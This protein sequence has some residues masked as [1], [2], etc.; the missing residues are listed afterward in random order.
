LKINIYLIIKPLNNFQIMKKLA[1]SFLAI[2][3]YWA[4][5]CQKAEMLPSSK[6]NR[7]ART[8]AAVTEVVPK[9]GTAN[10]LSYKEIEV[11][12]SKWILE[13]PIDESPLSDISGTAFAA[14][15][16]PIPG[17]MILSSNFGGESVRSAT[18]PRDSYIYLP[19]FGGTGW[20]YSAGVDECDN[21][22]IPDGHPLHAATNAILKPYMLAQKTSNLIAQVDGQDIV[23]DLT[24]CLVVTEPFPLMAHSTFNNPACDYTGKTATAVAFD[25]AV[26]LKLSP[27]PHTIQFSGL[28][29]NKQ[30]FSGVTWH[31][32]VE[33]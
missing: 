7:N 10:G 12:Y 16:Q 6:T 25:F 19:I 15:N 4:I 17:I 5:S 24:K 26:M 28:T 2:S 27:G 31:V 21:S 1:F 29:T 23:S 3:M 32:F 13:V 22:K 11:A 14:S 18:I 9:D 20:R 8:A 33:E 30:F